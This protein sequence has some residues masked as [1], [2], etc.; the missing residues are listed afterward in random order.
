[1]STLRKE[2]MILEVVEDDEG[3]PAIELPPS[4]LEE[5]GWKEGDVLTWSKGEGDSWILS[6]QPQTK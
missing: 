1:M 3:N 2:G 5:L 6:K 4:V